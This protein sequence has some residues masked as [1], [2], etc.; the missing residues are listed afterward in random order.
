VQ[1]GAHNS[2]RCLAA[3]DAG[4]PSCVRSASPWPWALR[5]GGA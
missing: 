3:T 1:A 2:R 5:P 4:G